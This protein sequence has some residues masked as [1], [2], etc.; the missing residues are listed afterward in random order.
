[1]HLESI[2]KMDIF[3]NGRARKGW[4][5]S[6]SQNLNKRRFSDTSHEKT[7]FLRL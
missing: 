6:C 3:Q 2:E 4:I 7:I 1:M 5:N